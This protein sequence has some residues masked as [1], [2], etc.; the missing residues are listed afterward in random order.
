MDERRN[1]PARWATPRGEADSGR[2][3]CQR[4]RKVQGATLKMADVSPGVGKLE[5]STRRLCPVMSRKRDYQERSQAT[6]APGFG[7]PVAVLN[8]GPSLASAGIAEV[9]YFALAMFVR[10]CLGGQLLRLKFRPRCMCWPRLDVGNL[11]NKGWGRSRKKRVETGGRGGRGDWR[12]CWEAIGQGAQGTKYR[13]SDGR[14]D[15]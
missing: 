8:R 6:S 3:S 15:N 12:R 13:W 10:R 9:D 5:E 11:G 4:A 1:R 7:F 2:L 14:R